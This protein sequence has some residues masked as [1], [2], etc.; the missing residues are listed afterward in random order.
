MKKIFKIMICSL[1]LI[2][3]SSCGCGKTIKHE[4]I[5]ISGY[6]AYDF[7]GAKSNMILVL[8]DSTSDEY[9]ELIS[10]LNK[11]I[12]F[13]DSNIYYVDLSYSD[14]L[15]YEML[16]AAFGNDGYVNQLMCIQNGRVVINQVETID[17]DTIATIIKGKKYRSLDLTEKEKEK[18]SYYNLAKKA[19]QN[20]FIGEAFYFYTLSIPYKDTVKILN[21]N[22]FD[23]LNNWL[24]SETDDNQYTYLN[25]SFDRV[26]NILYRRYYK[27]QKKAF[28]ESKLVIETYNYYLQDDTIY[29]AKEGTKE[30]QRFYTIDELT[31][32]NLN[33]HT[34][35]RTYEF[36]PG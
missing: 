21:S 2:I 18:A 12:E 1:F 36:I 27:G 13:A 32:D 9:E 3:L 19:F 11:V 31:I 24:F 14:A 7:F 33:V 26:S 35:K 5:Q 29:V 28:D 16:N 15:Q 25:L 30:Y 20:G 4:L 6:D 17:Y 10:N 23:L 8:T 34:T 22:Q